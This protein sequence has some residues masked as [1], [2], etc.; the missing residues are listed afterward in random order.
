MEADVKIGRGVEASGA[1][2]DESGPLREE[3][4][5]R[6]EHVGRWQRLPPE[7]II[8]EG[9]TFAEVSV[10]SRRSD[11]ADPEREISLRTRLTRNITLERGFIPSPMRTVVGPELAVKAA[12]LGSVGILPRSY[13][14][15]EEHVEAVRAVKRQGWF[16]EDPETMRPEQTVGE[17]RRV[18]ETEGIGSIL[19]TREDGRLVGLF[20]SG[21]DLDGD[22][23]RRL[24]EAMVPRDQLVT[25]SEGADVEQA[26]RLFEQSGKKKLPV[27]DAD[28]V[29]RGLYTY[30]DIR[31]LREHPEASRDDKGRPLV[32]AAIS[33]SETDLPRAAALVE[34]SADFL[35]IDAGHGHVER[36][37]QQIRDL[38]SAHPGVDVIGGN[39]ITPEG[40]K[41]L[42]L[43]GADAIRVGGGSGS[44]C[45]TRGR[46][47]SGAAQ[48]AAV[49]ACREVARLAD[50]PVIS[51]GGIREEG[52]ISK[53]IVGGAETVM[54]GRK[55]AATAESAADV[56]E[57]DGMKHKRYIGEASR[58][59]LTSTTRYLDRERVS[60]PEGVES[61]IPQSGSVEEAIATMDAELWKAMLHTGS[62]TI[63]EHMTSHF[64]RQSAASIAEGQPH[65]L[66]AVT[67]TG[68]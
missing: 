5:T 67:D 47:G 56:Q 52:D 64:T 48:L 32:G 37:E 39:V 68:R 19:V 42:I 65:D 41:D 25:L 43:A 1:V 50:V 57:K 26:K 7:A 4:E 58:D 27:V 44:V 62:R 22:P 60:I 63:S 18:M 49:M 11:I 53:A 61:L 40:T 2:R 66:A 36:A 16:I 28:G 54:M 35:V 9:L 23:G 21:H 51:D 6:A 20:T 17:A 55:F 34:S 8:R 29:Q 13:E 24:E 12:Q 45:I 59:A 15:I 30:K 46:I 33:M 10:V 14:T 3:L 38:N 31:A